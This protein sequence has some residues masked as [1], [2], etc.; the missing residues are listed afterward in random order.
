[1]YSIDNEETRKFWRHRNRSRKILA[2][3]EWSL[4]FV[5]WAELVLYVSQS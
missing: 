1:M 3:F 5:L 2:K 4:S